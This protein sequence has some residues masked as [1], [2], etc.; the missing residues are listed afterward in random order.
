M[1]TDSLLLN[2]FAPVVTSNVARVILCIRSI[3]DVIRIII[4]NYLVPF[5]TSNCYSFKFFCIHSIL[6]VVQVTPDVF[7]IF[8]Q[9]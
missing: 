3:L 1:Y 9:D 5:V 2:F 6:D 8:S 4:D 7:F